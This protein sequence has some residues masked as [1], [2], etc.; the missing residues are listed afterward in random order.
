M[1]AGRGRTDGDVL[2]PLWSSEK[3]QPAALHL[4]EEVR[5]NVES[6]VTRGHLQDRRRAVAAVLDMQRRVVVIETR[7]TNTALDSTS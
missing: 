6:A 2:T 1:Q 3:H 7:R 4:D 5:H